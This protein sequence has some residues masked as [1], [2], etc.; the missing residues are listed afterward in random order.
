MMKSLLLLGA[1]LI[2]AGCST[3]QSRA[4]ANADLM[5]TFPPEVQA[6]VEAG[7]VDL[8]FTED[9]VMVAMGRPDRR[10]SQV[11]AAGQTT[12]WVYNRRGGQPRFSLGVGTG[13]GRGSGVYGGGISVGT[14]GRLGPEERARITFAEGKVIGIQHADR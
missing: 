11:T 9:M 1:I 6:R 5:A 14:G 7:E 13:I 2:L 3:P 4:R 8:G 10:L 12:T